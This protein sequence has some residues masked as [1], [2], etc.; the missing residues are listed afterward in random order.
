MAAEGL[1]QAR[2][3][4][5]AGRRVCPWGQRGKSDITPRHQPMT[6]RRHATAGHRAAQRARSRPCSHVTHPPA[7]KSRDRLKDA[8]GR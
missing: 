4:R 2:A 5:S 8:G 6:T 1:T 3:A 7:P